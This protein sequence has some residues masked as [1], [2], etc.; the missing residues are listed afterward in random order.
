METETGGMVEMMRA[1]PVRWFVPP[2]H[3][4]GGCRWLRGER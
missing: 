2:I 3:T 1:R 4:V